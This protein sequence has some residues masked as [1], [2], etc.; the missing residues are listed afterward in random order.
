MTTIIEIERIRY[1]ALST[2]PAYTWNMIVPSE[3]TRIKDGQF[4]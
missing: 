3:N 4:K 2:Y 1:V